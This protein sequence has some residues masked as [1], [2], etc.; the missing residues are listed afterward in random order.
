MR[1]PILR[2]PAGQRRAPDHE[3][4][5]AFWVSATL[6]KL[7][8]PVRTTAPSM[9]MILLWAMAC[10]SSIRVGMP[11]CATKSAED[12]FSVRWLLSRMISTRTP[13]RG[14]STKALAIGAEVKEYACT[15]TVC[16]APASASTTASVQPPFGEKYAVIV[17]SLIGATPALQPGPGQRKV[18]TRSV[19]T[20]ACPRHNT[21]DLLGLHDLPVPLATVRVQLPQT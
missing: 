8:D 14:A 12:Y 13:R 2:V 11:A 20:I 1:L 21:D 19:A 17:A 16:L 6:V 10:L 15:R 18:V 3:E 9:I 7:K 5:S 4:V